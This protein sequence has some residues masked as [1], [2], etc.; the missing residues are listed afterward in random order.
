MLQTY[1]FLKDLLAGIPTGEDQKSITKSQLRKCRWHQNSSKIPTGIRWN[2]LPEKHM[3]SAI[4][5][6]HERAHNIYRL[7]NGLVFFD[8]CLR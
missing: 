5:K 8:G 3:G 7:L 2:I 4:V 6:A 1:D